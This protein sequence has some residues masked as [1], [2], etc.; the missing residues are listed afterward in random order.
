MSTQAINNE[1][2]RTT[3]LELAEKN[4]GLKKIAE[5]ANINYS[6]LHN[7]LNRNAGVLAYTISL[8]TIGIKN[9]RL[10][11]KVCDPAGYIPIQKQAFLRT[12]HKSIRKREVDLS[13][14]I[15][16]ALNIIE[17]AH[18]DGKITKIEYRDIHS[19]LNE[20]MRKEAEL[21]YQIKGEV[22]G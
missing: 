9:P 20:L 6:T 4:G 22:K 3:I 7:Q 5:K 11:E 17:E 18:K 16:N 21:D 12:K 15:G 19:V 10:L 1:I 8:I 14:T 2:I 13:I